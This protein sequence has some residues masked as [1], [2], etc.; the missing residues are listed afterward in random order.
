MNQV[1]TCHSV[2]ES[3]MAIAHVTRRRNPWESNHLF[4]LSSC[5]MEASQ[6]GV[7]WA[8][9]IYDM[10]W[11]VSCDL[12][13]PVTHDQ[14]TCSTF[15]LFEHLTRASLS[16]RYQKSHCLRICMGKLTSGRR[17]LATK[18]EKCCAYGNVRLTRAC[19][20]QAESTPSNPQKW[21]LP[22]QGITLFQFHFLHAWVKASQQYEPN[23]K[24]SM[25][26]SILRSCWTTCHRAWI[27]R[28]FTSLPNSGS[29]M[30]CKDK[31]V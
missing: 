29:S 10:I 3:L 17:C 28:S 4:Q 14:L 22:S 25:H 19:I 21:D 27:S 18:H 31:I 15:H 13:C 9:I 30:S 24:K 26:C 5:S 16:Q 2:R 1:F 12:T 6:P 11:R 23:V 7:I 20:R 8:W